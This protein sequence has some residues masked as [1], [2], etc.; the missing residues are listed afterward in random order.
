MKPNLLWAS[1]DLAQ[2]LVAPAAFPVRET[3]RD[4]RPFTPFGL[5][6]LRIF[7]FGNAVKINLETGLIAE[8]A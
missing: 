2:I 6:N 4:S 5:K 7:T 8:K 3:R 1:R